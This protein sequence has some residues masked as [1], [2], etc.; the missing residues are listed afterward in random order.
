MT[1]RSAADAF[2]EGHKKGFH[3][4]YVAAC[5]ELRHLIMSLERVAAYP[6]DCHI[7]ERYHEIFRG[8]DDTTHAAESLQI[9]QEALA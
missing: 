1:D 2:D 6:D 5:Q 8:L 3:A 7:E 9:I 4:G